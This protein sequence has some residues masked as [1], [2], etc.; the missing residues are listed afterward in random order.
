NKIGPLVAE[1]QWDRVQGYIQK[2]MDEGATVLVGGKGKPEGLEQGYFAKPTVFTDVDNDMTIAQG[3][4]FGRVTTLIT[5]D[6]LAE[7]HDIANDNIYGLAVYF[8]V[9]EE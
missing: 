1:K 7:E 2:G 6:S 5:Y 9:T 8:V 4:I 3:E